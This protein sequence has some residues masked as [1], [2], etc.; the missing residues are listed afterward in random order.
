MAG[1]NI[2]AVET[3]RFSFCTWSPR[4]QIL[5]IETN[6]PPEIDVSYA[7]MYAAAMMPKAP[8]PLFPIC[9]LPSSSTLI[10]VISVSYFFPLKN[11]NPIN[12]P[13]N[14]PVTHCSQPSLTNLELNY[15]T[16]VVCVHHSSVSCAILSSTF[17]LVYWTLLSIFFSCAM[18]IL[19]SKNTSFSRQISCANTS[20]DWHRERCE[21]HVIHMGGGRLSLASGTDPV[22]DLRI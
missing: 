12:I 3:E 21:T 13:P 22:G 4:S 7:G 11:P 8:S 17:G 5:P 16:H 6:W 15:M 18:N 20:A 1:V 19:C 14:L 10:S 9:C 2:G